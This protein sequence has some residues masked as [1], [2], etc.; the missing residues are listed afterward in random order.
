MRLD[1]VVSELI[2]VS[3]NKS[4]ELIKEERVFLNFV[5]EPRGTKEVKVSDILTI[6]GKGRFKI[7]EII[8]R[9]RNERFVIKVQKYV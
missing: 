5:V 2:K 9:T 6:R 3:R 1:S 4:S 7:I 8:R